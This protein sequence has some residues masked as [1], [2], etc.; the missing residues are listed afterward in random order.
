ADGPRQ[1]PAAA[2]GGPFLSVGHG[3]H[4]ALHSFPT[5]RSSDLW[6][7]LI[8]A[9]DLRAGERVL[10]VG[11][12]GGVNSTAIQIAKFAGAH[13]FAITSRSEEHTSELQSRENLVCRLLLEK[14]KQN[15]QM[16]GEATLAQ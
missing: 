6:H 3:A 10:V 12:G 2:Y 8:V 5:R 11:A 13:V 16:S 7:N 14:K 4:R 15:W 1:L 9:G